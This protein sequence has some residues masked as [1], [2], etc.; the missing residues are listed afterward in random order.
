MG[1]ISR[2]SGQTKSASAF[3]PNNLDYPLIAI[4]WAKSKLYFNN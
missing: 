4:L 3:H 1:D 2:Y